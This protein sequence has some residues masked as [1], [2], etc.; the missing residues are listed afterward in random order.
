M[1]SPYFPSQDKP[2]L[3]RYSRLRGVAQ[4]LKISLPARLRL[5]WFIFYQTEGERNVS[6]TARY[7]GISRKTL[8]KCLNRFD[9]GN[10]RS[11]EENS[12]RP[13]RVR[14][15]EVTPD[16]EARI[17]ALRQKHLKGGKN[18]LA[19]IYQKVHH[20]TISAWKVERV[21][22]KHRL[23]PDLKAYKKKVRRQRLRQANPKVRI[24]RLKQ[25]GF[26]PAPGKLWHTDSV[27]IWWY[28]QRRVILTA[29][30]DQ[31]RLG[32]ARAY[33]NGS[34]RQAADFLN[35]LVYLS[36]GDIRIIHS[37]NGSE[38]A[39]EFEKA[40]QLLNLQ[41]I[42]SRV[43]TPK[44]NSVLERFNRTVQEEW[45]SLSEAG[46]DDLPEANRDLTEWLVEYNSVRPHQSLAY[47]TPL[48]YAQEN[49]FKVLPMWSAS[50][51]S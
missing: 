35:R 32:Y 37:D 23:Y 51:A 22:R 46:L 5:E 33:S 16:Q 4:L 28:G 18:K 14:R 12:R 34:S 29:I 7:F 45:L 1:I 38:F 30:E 41:Q 31:T 9:E 8:H 17:I 40:C 27:I 50:T 20:E 26:I 44:D 24:N 15:W 49:Y 36:D 43:K 48:E 3:G 6:K 47:Q 39:G 25:S 13:H 11:L 42:Y 21:V 10:L 2:L 19:L